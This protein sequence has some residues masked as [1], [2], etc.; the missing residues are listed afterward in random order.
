MPSVAQTVPLHLVPTPITTTIQEESPP[1]DGISATPNRRPFVIVDEDAGAT[2]M[3]TLGV[4]AFGIYWHLCRR[5]RD[6]QCWP[7]LDDISEATGITT[8]HIR[9]MLNE[10]EENGWISREKRTNAYGMQTSTLYTITVK[11]CT[12]GGD[13]ARTLL[14]HDPASNVPLTIRKPDGEPEG[15]SNPP[16]PKTEY[17]DEFLDLWR[18]YPPGNGSKAKTYQQWRRVKAEH[19]DIMAGLAKWKL[20]ERW[21]KGYVKTAELWI[22]DRLW[23]NPPV[24]ATNGNGAI[25]WKTATPEQVEIYR[26]QR[27]REMMSRING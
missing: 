22:R 26:L 6:G 23:E 7:S 24:I 11:P 13:I 3:A 20:S 12:N 19:Q 27:E 14:G 1:Y 17:P 16:P 10:L 2:I 9:R 8:R 25:D 4:S 21:Q 5:A 15:D 18:S